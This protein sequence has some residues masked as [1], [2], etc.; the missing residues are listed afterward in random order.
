MPEPGAS[1]VRLARLAVGLSQGQLARAA[2]VSR[3]AIAGLEA[4][5]WDPSLRVAV[6]LSRALG[7]PVEELFGPDPAPAPLT[8]ELAEGS[9]LAP[10]RVGLSQV[11]GR[12]VAFP[13]VG[14]AAMACGFVPASATVAGRPRR[15]R[16]ARLA[17]APLAPAGPSL[18]VA[19]C[20]PA[21]PLLQGPLARLDPPVSLTWWPCSSARALELLRR[22]AVHAAGVHVLDAA[23]GTY[24]RRAAERAL[25]RLGAEVVGFASW[26]QGLVLARGLGA[27]GGLADALE[28][29]WRLAN[30]E[31]G[32]EARSVLD[33]ELA[34]LGARGEDVPGYRSRLGGHLLVASAVA[35]GLADF[36]V[37]CEPAAA[38]YG[39]GF[40]PLRAERYDL[41]VARPSLGLPEVRALLA[42][43][44]GPAFRAQLAAI[45]G[46]DASVCGTVGGLA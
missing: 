31:P 43:L 45:P 32:A 24:N 35:S 1:R 44:A 11:T 25:G 12:A 37:A 4:G 22:G 38:A 17:V 29:G 39:L 18:A 3:Q 28:R 26:R 14:D 2:G 36:G 9:P 42:V 23:S 21:L 13:L 46:Y 6:A 33:A 5:R 15:R 40:R 30:R 20:D 7:R 41:V 10:A 8:A 34:R 16:G 27:P 19:G